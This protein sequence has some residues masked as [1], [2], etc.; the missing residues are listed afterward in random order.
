MKNIFYYLAIFLGLAVTGCEPMEDIH[1]EINASLDNELA[2]GDITYTLTEDDYDELGLNFPNFNSVDDAK[3]LLPAYLADMYPYYGSKST[4]NITFDI[5]APKSTEKFLKAYSVT[6][7]DYDS[8]ED[9]EKYDNF[10]DEDQIYTFLN[11]K[12]PD[13]E[14][15]T[16]ISLTYKFYDGSLKTLN[17]G[18]L[19]VN[20]EFTKI[21]GLTDAE[22][23]MAGEGYANFSTEDEALA[24]LPVFLKEKYKYELLQAGDIKPIMYKLYT[25]DVQDID[26]DG[27]TTDSAV[28]SYV[29]YFI[30]DGTNF[31]PYNNTLSQSIQFG[32]ID[33]VWIPDNTIRYSLAGSDYSLVGSAFADIYEGPAANVG[34]YQSF[35]G[36]SSSGNYWNPDMLVEAM[37]AVLDNLMPNAEEGQQYVV[38]FAVYNGSVVNQELSLI[39]EGGEWVLNQ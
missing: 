32:N 7:E 16:L 5:Y 28:Y 9:T 27:S 6:T 25:T 19:Y 38:T 34:N 18:F 17:N 15:R 26:G 13:I 23:N 35:D 22:Y 24:K 36:R 29:K 11:D 30:F 14:N 8:Y 3:E 20:G 33:G 39:K 2:V 4:A 37:N 21:E 31:S 12:F 1:N 10:D